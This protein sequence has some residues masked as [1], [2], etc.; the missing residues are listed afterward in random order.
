MIRPVGT[1]P[2]SGCACRLQSARKASAAAGLVPTGNRPYRLPESWTNTK[3]R[4]EGENGVIDA[5]W[6][7]LRK[8]TRATGCEPGRPHFFLL[9]TCWPIRIRTLTDRTKICSATVTP[10][11]TGCFVKKRGKGNR[12]L[13]FCKVNSQIFSVFRLVGGAHSR[14]CKAS[15]TAGI[16]SAMVWSRMPAAGAPALPSRAADSRALLVASNS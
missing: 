3:G 12:K 5:G 11:A 8:I 14:S 10:W 6:K 16:S 9:S 4:R 2:T 7:K 1:P 13:F 15:T